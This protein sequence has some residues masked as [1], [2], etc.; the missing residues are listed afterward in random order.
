MS[1]DQTDPAMD[2]V[3]VRVTHRGQR[4]DKGRVCPHCG[5]WTLRAMID[6]SNPKCM[7]CGAA[8]ALEPKENRP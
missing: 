6:L 2:G 5:A 3:V 7:R 4:E 1:I 8:L